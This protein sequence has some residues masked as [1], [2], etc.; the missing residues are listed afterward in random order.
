MDR[1]TDLWPED[2]GNRF[3]EL[4]PVFDGRPRL[5]VLWP[6][7]DEGPETF[8]ARQAEARASGAR[9]VVVAFVTP[10]ERPDGQS[11]ATEYERRL[12]QDFGNATA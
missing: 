9:V 7:G 3:A 1:V 12:H 4:A 2:D 8:A 11:G 10:P 5:A 6:R